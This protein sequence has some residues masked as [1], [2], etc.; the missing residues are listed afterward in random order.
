VVPK[1]ERD[2]LPIIDAAESKEITL[3]VSAY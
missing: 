1:I 2:G 3:A